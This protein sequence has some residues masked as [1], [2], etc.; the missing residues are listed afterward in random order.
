MSSVAT[1]IHSLD[2]LPAGV[3]E[4]NPRQRIT[5]RSITMPSEAT[6]AEFKRA[7]D[8]GPLPERDI[9]KA[10]AREPE[11]NTIGDK[12]AAL[13]GTSCKWPVGNVGEEDFHFCMKAKGGPDE[14]PYCPEHRAIAGGGF[15]SRKK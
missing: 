14:G 2:L 8:G 10:P 13:T 5:P 1:A 12:V 11:R 6:L 15:Y 4:H 9:L 3:R 7:H